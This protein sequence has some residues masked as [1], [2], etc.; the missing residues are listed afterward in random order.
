M[1]LLIRTKVEKRLVYHGSGKE[2]ADEDTEDI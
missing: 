1:E 2:M